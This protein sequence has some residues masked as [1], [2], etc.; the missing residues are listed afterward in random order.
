MQSCF[1][2]GE[3][4]EYLIGVFAILHALNECLCVM[5]LPRKQAITLTYPFTAFYSPP[6]RAFVLR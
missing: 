2:R 4:Y 1:P 5:C 6:L 3:V